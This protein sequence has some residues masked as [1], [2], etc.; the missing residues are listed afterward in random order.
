MARVGHY[1]ISVRTNIMKIM[2]DFMR[3]KIISV[4]GVYRYISVRSWEEFSPGL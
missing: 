4:R 1:M 3:T 2:S